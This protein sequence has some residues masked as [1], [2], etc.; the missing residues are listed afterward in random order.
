[1]NWGRVKAAKYYGSLQSTNINFLLGLR[2]M[3]AGNFVSFDTGKWDFCSQGEDLRGLHPGAINRTTGQLSHSRHVDLDAPP[4]LPPF[5]SI[6]NPCPV[7]KGKVPRT[8]RNSATES[9]VGPSSAPACV[10]HNP[11]LINRPCI[12]LILSRTSS[13]NLNM[14]LAALRSLSG[15]G[16]SHCQEPPRA[17]QAYPPVGN[18]R[19]SGSLPSLA[20][21][22][23]QSFTVSILKAL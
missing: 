14:V 23:L 13:V 15:A 11:T 19:Q 17:S 3:H 7:S 2:H 6:T 5:N 9:P 4:L 8:N 20:S 21:R 12:S 1:M 22:D 18:P 16:T 10:A